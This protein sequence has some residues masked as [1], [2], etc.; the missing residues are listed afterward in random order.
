MPAEVDES[1]CDGC[2]SCVE[3]CPSEAITVEDVARVNPDECVDCGACVDACPKG[4]I[5][6]P[7]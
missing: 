5:T 1:K 6:L 4:A 2:R 7:G 3:V